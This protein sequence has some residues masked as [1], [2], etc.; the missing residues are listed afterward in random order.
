MRNANIAYTLALNLVKVELK[1]HGIDYK[2]NQ[3]ICLNNSGELLRFSTSNEKLFFQVESVKSSKSIFID[4]NE[5]EIEKADKK[6]IEIFK[7]LKNEL[8]I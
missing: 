6:A 8:E 2:D 7:K 3:S 5:L 4:F 1:K